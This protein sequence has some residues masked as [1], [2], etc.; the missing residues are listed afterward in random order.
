MP[1]QELVQIKQS[2]DLEKNTAVMMA[3]NCAPVIKGSKASNLITVTMQEFYMIRKLVRGTGISYH[4]LKIK[5]NKFMLFCIGE[6]HSNATF[7][8]RRY[9]NF[10]VVMAIRQMIFLRCCI[11]CFRVWNS[12]AE[13]RLHIHMRWELSWSIRSRTS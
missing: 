11:D 5:A 1:I 7:Y 9:R 13:E 12:I 4:L 10:C 6:K 8:L 3:V 2:N